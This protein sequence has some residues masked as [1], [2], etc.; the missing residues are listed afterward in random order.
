MI[1]TAIGFLAGSFQRGDD[2]ST[3]QRAEVRD[4]A[5]ADAARRDRDVVLSLL[6]LCCTLP[7]L[8]IVAVL[9]KLESPGPVLYRQERVGLRGRCFDLWKFRSMRTDAEVSG[10]VWAAR[11]DPRVTKVG[12]FIRAHRIDELP[13]LVNVLRG[14]MSLVGPRPERPI[15]VRQLAE[16]IPGFGQRTCVPPGL[17]GW[18]QVN[19]PYGASVEDARVKLDHDLYY[20]RERSL[21][22]DAR[23]LFRTVGVVLRRT[24]AR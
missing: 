23:I 1:S 14:E 5:L 7:L 11:H 2:R 16:V 20:I 8:A 15:F 13:Q 24:G 4:R 10:P 9:I 17:T 21:G 18:A 19:C 6:L 12:A 22:L 3:V